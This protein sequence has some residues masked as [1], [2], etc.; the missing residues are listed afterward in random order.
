MPLALWLTNIFRLE[1][2]RTLAAG[3]A[4]VADPSNLTGYSCQRGFGLKRMKWRS[5]LAWLAV[6]LVLAGVTPLI[7]VV[8]WG[9]LHKAEAL[10]APVLLKPGQYVSPF[11]T[12]DLNDDCQIEI[13]LLPP[14]W[15][16]LEMD[17]KVVD[18][19][20]ALMDGGAHREDQQVGGND[21]I[22]DR[23]YWPKRRTLQRVILQI[24][25]GLQEAP[26]SDVRLYVGVPERGL[27]QDGSYAARVLLLILVSPGAGML[28][29]LWILRPFVEAGPRPKQSVE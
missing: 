10:S 16:P 5:I 11:F 27:Q 3:L 4:L 15:M 19:A 14:G 22:L 18:Q 2:L 20:G 26:G 13:Y 24:H 25:R 12:T 9:Y 28:V 17:W 29:V 1:F 6:L 8:C 7:F 21:A 23:R